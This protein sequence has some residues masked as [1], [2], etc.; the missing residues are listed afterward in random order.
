MLGFTVDTYLL[1]LDVL[2]ALPLVEARSP[3]LQ[4]IGL[5]VLLTLTLAIATLGADRRDDVRLQQIYLQV[6]LQR[7]RHHV[8]GTPGSSVI[9]GF[10]SGKK[11]DAEGTSLLI[12]RSLQ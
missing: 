3:V 4:D 6:L 5:G 11:E 2:P 8:L 12:R 10:Q 7:I 1:A 9:I